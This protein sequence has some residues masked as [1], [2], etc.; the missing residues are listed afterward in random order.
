MLWAALGTYPDVQTLAVTYS[1]FDFSGMPEMDSLTRLSL[2]QCSAEIA[3]SLV[4]ISNRC[5]QLAAM[6]LSFTTNDET[7]SQLTLPPTGCLFPAVT[8]LILS[9]CRVDMGSIAQSF[10]RLTH[11]GGV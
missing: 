6:K 8:D 3:G 10:P 1:S 4:T 5:P 2:A 9:G 7:V 11:F